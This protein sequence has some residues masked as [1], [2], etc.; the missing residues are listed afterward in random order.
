[1]LLR[2]RQ[3]TTLAGS[4]LLLALFTSCENEDS[5]TKF[6][7]KVI[8]PDTNQAFAD[9]RVDLFLSDGLPDTYTFFTPVASSSTTNSQGEYEFIHTPQARQTVYWVASEKKGYVEVKDGLG[10]EIKRNQT[11]NMDVFLAKGSY[12]EVSVTNA[13]PSP[14][15]SLKVSLTYPLNEAASPVKGIMYGGDSMIFNAAT[16]T[17]K[18]VRGFYYKRTSNV[19]VEWEVTA[20]GAIETKS[21]TVPLV[22]YD[23]ARFEISY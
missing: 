11:N 15:K 7:G 19:K 21:T 20:A 12:L 10:K 13:A 8:D 14:D 4:F 22:E 6:T 17:D 23:T 9:T 3:L 18:F 2:A 16:T 1:M 5:T